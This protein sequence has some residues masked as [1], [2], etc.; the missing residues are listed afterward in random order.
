MRTCR[1][2]FWR[3]HLSGPLRVHLLRLHPVT[4]EVNHCIGSDVA[5]DH[6]P[7]VSAARKFD[8]LCEEDRDGIIQPWSHLP[9]ARRASNR[10][11]INNL[12]AIAGRI[13]LESLRIER[14]VG[15]R[16]RWG[17]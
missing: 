13:D 12:L 6:E 15:L 1:L 9:C 2:A 16:M 5:A 8:D 11:A 7:R 17:H 3:E 4:W 10:D 14:R